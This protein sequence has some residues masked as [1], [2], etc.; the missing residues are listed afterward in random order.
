MLLACGPV[1][2]LRLVGNDDG[3]GVD[4]GGVAGDKDL[5]DQGAPDQNA[6]HPLGRNVLALHEL[7]Q[8]LPAVNDL[9]GAIRQK[10]GDVPGEQPPVVEG[11]VSGVLVPE[12]AAGHVVAADQQ[13]AARVG[14]RDEVLELGQGF[15][16][17]LERREGPADVRG[18]RLAGGVDEGA[19]SSLGEA[20]AGNDV[21]AENAPDLV[22]G[23][24]RKRRRASHH[25]PDVA[26]EE[27][28]ELLK[29]DPVPEGVPAVAGGADAPQLGVEGRAEEPLDDAGLPRDIGEDLVV[30]AE[31]EPRHADEHGGLE[32]LEVLE[33]VADVAAVDAD[34]AAHENAGVDVDALVHV[35]ERQV[36]EVA[37]DGVHAHAAHLG[38]GAGD[39]GDGGGHLPLGE[40]DALWHARGA[41]SV[42]NGVDH[43]RSGRPEG[44]HIRLAP[45]DHLVEEEDLHLVLP[46]RD[47]LVASHDDGGDGVLR[48]LG[49]HRN[50]LLGARV[51]ADDHVDVGILQNVDDGVLADGVVY[52]HHGVAVR[53]RRLLA[54]EPLDAV[55]GVDAEHPAVNRLGGQHLHRLDAV[56]GEEPA[57]ELLHDG[58]HLAVGLEG[59]LPERPIALEHPRAEAR[60]VGTQAEAPL[61]DFP[62]EGV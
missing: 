35:G 52:G 7:E 36:A 10:L 16:P 9:D 28:R 12:V 38:E 57:A 4:L 8:V 3:N 29:D 47:Y 41:G 32:R 31:E 5:A 51:V 55:D 22:V 46:R 26:A 20:V 44:H 60:A 39:D 6:L 43:L 37:L 42:G 54:D 2:Q 25:P 50:E 61:E 34:A 59:E 53:V 40:N 45:L 17:E 13:L 48:C 58:L 23:G 19:S 1:L 11:L 24:R 33:D 30:D 18:V 62:P 14:V 27:R 21:G 15:Q 49:Q 56:D